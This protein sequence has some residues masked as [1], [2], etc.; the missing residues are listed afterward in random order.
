MSYQVRQAAAL[1]N[2]TAAKN[3]ALSALERRPPYIVG[4][5]DMKIPS[6]GDTVPLVFCKVVDGVGGAWIAPPL[7]RSGLSN[8][9]NTAL[10][11][12][13]LLISQG[14]ITS[15]IASTAD[16]IVGVRRITSGFS[17][18]Y[19]T[20]YGSLPAASNFLVNTNQYFDT[21]TS[22]YY[23]TPIGA[24]GSAYYHNETAPLSETGSGSIT[25][26]SSSPY[27]TSLS[28]KTTIFGGDAFKVYYTRQIGNIITRTSN[29]ISSVDW[30][31]TF[32]DETGTLSSGSSFI[33]ATENR[34]P[35]TT[36]TN[37][38]VTLY[39]PTFSP[40]EFIDDTTGPI[41]KYYSNFSVVDQ[42]VFEVTE[43]IRKPFFVPQYFDALAREN[44][45]GDFSDCT[46]L[47]VFLNITLLD[48]SDPLY[49]GSTIID[50]TNNANK[51][52]VTI[53]CSNGINVYNFLT[54]T[55]GPSNNVCDLIN[56]LVSTVDSTATADTTSLLQSANFTQTNGLLF[57]GAITEAVNLKEW[58]DNMAPFFLLTPLNLE[59]KV[60]A[61][62]ALPITGAYQLDTG[63]LTPQITFTDDTIAENSYSI[64]YIP[65]SERKPFKAV[66]LWRDSG[67]AYDNNIWPYI[68]TV[69]VSY[70]ADTGNIPEEQ[71][72]MSDFCVTASHATLV[73]KYLL[74]T[75]KH[76]S[77]TVQFTTDLYTTQGLLPGALIAV[78]Q[79]RAT[80][81][82]TTRT[83]TEHYLVDSISRSVDGTAQISAAHFPLTEG[84]ASVITADI[85]GGSFTVV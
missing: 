8:I 84:G 33:G 52:Q 31:Y 76:T 28:W 57:N 70:T 74:A 18:T 24:G 13:A 55:T 20:T 67:T 16:I 46:V 83:E 7:V 48:A 64:T 43:T 39:D 6:I 29:T 3:N 49:A 53:K 14:Q 85:T 26:T 36:L 30:A 19:T 68:T 75:R 4:S 66:M 82:G 21:E 58:L 69:K 78:Q 77:H 54:A 5:S 45:D 15:P 61:R 40:E 41:T 73:A 37:L 34:S 22:T 51:K 47:T 11:K 27:C 2:N 80:S 81:E 32:T 12:H 38:S 17:A 25:I 44:A 50:D 63:A 72:D 79:V 9:N 23:T 71:Y 62:P 56:Y 60:G 59:S 1:T 65:L 35:S 10:V 42:Q